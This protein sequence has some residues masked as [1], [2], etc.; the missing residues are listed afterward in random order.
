[1]NGIRMAPEE[2]EAIIF[3]VPGVT[4][5]SVV[6]TGGAIVAFYTGNDG[7]LEMSMPGLAQLIRGQCTQ[8]LPVS[9]RPHYIVNLKVMPTLPN[10]KVDLRALVV[11]ATDIVSEQLVEVVDSLGQMTRVAKEDC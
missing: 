1:M 6:G 9:M 5:V 10:G 7:P 11:Q 3:E 4:E 2:I 8:H